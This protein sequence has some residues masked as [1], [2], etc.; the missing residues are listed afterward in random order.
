M[1]Q[2]VFEFTFQCGCTAHCLIVGNMTAEDIE[3]IKVQSSR[4][5]CPECNLAYARL[6]EEGNHSKMPSC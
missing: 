1:D 2:A 6:M 3:K 5:P 4:L